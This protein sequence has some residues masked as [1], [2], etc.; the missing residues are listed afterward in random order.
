[1]NVNAYTANEDGSLDIFLEC[2]DPC[3]PLTDEYG[4]FVVRIP[5]HDVT[6]FMY[7]AIDAL[8]GKVGTR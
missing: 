6:R 7:A 1:M 5:A 2:D 4:C 3:E 8:K